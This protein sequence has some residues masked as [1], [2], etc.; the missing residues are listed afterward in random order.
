[1]RHRS[2]AWR[3]LTVKAVALCALGACV[4]F[5]SH[6]CT[7]RAS[8]QRQYSAVIR[9]VK[10][11]SPKKVKFAEIDPNQFYLDTTGGEGG[12]P[13]GI[14][15]DLITKS[16]GNG[17][18]HGRGDHDAAFQNFKDRMQDGKPF[19]GPD[20][21]TGWIWAVADLTVE[22]GLRLELRRSVPVGM[23]ALMSAK[24]GNA[25]ELFESV[26]WAVVRRRLN[27]ILGHRDAEGVIVPG[28]EAA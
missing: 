12:A 8:P 10:F 22:D 16:F 4:A 7:G 27:E 20:D 13:K 23:R 19:E 11:V 6:T 24:I 25:K 21:G 18:F 28:Y 17:D 9:H 14:E 2:G 26:D 5:V 3:N 1:M 15:R